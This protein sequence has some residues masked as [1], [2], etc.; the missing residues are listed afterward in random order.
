MKVNFRRKARQ[1]LWD[2]IAWYEKQRPGLG[3][4]F[5]KAMDLLLLRIFE[6]PRRFQHLSARV[7]KARLERFPYHVYFTQPGDGIQ[8]TAIIHNK[9][10][11]EWVAQRLSE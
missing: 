2:T 1:E 4:E 7:G 11:P 6:N 8:I 5:E 9:R 10:G 3:N